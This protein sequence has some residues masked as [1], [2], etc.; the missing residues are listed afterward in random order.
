MEFFA[1]DK[2][3]IERLR[4][5]DAA[6]EG[7]FV[8]YFGQYFRILL[9]ARVLSPDKV[10]DVTQETFRRVLVAL[11]REDA[12]HQPERFGAFVNS[13]CRNALRELQRGGKRAE[14][15]EDVHYEVPDP[16]PD[17]HALLVSQES[18]IIVRRVLSG[19]PKKDSDLLRELFFLEK[20]KDEICRQHSVDREYLRVL[21]HRA[22]GRFRAE[23]EA[24]TGV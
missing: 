24:Q 7:H 23:Y 4:A 3:Y 13:I 11:H 15:L 6:T 21:M 5:G 2:D 9:R 12:I 10:D 1:F 19:M 22:K 8:G 17:A 16:A 14:P 18:R 20:D